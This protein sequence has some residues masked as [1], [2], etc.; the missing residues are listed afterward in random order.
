M[1]GIKDALLRM[2]TAAMNTK[3]LQ[4]A[5]VDA[6]LKDNM[7]FGVYSDIADA[8]YHL[9][10]EETETFE[11]SVTSIA[12]ETPLLNTNR[13]VEILMAEYRKNHP[14]QPSPYIMSSDGLREL[15]ERNGGYMTPEGDW[16]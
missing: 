14:E 1:N 12:L 15:Y 6:G 9:I 13:R 11:S 3:R 10:G 4:E 7:V 8:I 16:S 2:V 5:F